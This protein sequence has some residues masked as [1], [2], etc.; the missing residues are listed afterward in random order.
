MNQLKK[1]NVMHKL[2]MQLIAGEIVFKAAEELNESWNKGNRIQHTSDSILG[3][4]DIFNRQ[5]EKVFNGIYQEDQELIKKSLD[6]YLSDREK[7]KHDIQHDKVDKKLFEPIKAYI[8]V[9]N[10]IINMLKEA[11]N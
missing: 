6:F 3:K 7:L 5:I 11:L 8:E 4:I 9:L 2:I 10:N 1:L